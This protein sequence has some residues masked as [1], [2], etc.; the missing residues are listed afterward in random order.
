M[1]AL[2]DHPPD[3]LR[4]YDG[5]GDRTQGIQIAPTARHSGRI[6]EGLLRP[7]TVQSE[8][9]RLTPRPAGCLIRVGAMSR[10]AHDLITMN[11]AAM[12]GP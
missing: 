10:G 3:F 9:I 6:V 12:I 8:D 4:V 11:H 1:T 7:R 2:H 5:N